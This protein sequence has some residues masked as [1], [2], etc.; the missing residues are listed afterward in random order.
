MIEVNPDGG[1]DPLGSASCADMK[2]F[3]PEDDSNEIVLHFQVSLSHSTCSCLSHYAHI[4]VAWLQYCE[5]SIFLYAVV[6]TSTTGSARL[7]Q[8]A[9]HKTHVSA[10]SE[11]DLHNY[12][13]VCPCTMHIC[14]SCHE[15]SCCNIVMECL[16]A[17]PTF[18][19][20]KTQKQGAMSDCVWCRLSCLQSSQTHHRTSRTRRVPLTM[21]SLPMLW[22]LGPV[23]P[24]AVLD[25][26]FLMMVSCEEP[27]CGSTLHCALWCSNS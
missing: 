22:G 19:V 17:W 4:P 27:D 9:L 10:K 11:H 1:F 16:H 21:G 18:Q 12:G 7:C 5:M 2:T 3:F 8:A 6:T 26:N 15:M 14:S 20:T 24:C 13:S 23:T 25:P